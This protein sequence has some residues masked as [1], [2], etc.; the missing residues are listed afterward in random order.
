VL[1][2]AR[3][4]CRAGAI[5]STY[6]LL[7]NRRHSASPPRPRH[8][9]LRQRRSTRLHPQVRT[10]RRAVSA[11][12]SKGPVISSYIRWPDNVDTSSPDDFGIT[13]RTPASRRSCSGWS[14]RRR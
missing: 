11:R 2:G 7:R 14:K 9:L 3:V 4:V 6:L 1:P 10:R 12:G 5:G 8:T 13:S